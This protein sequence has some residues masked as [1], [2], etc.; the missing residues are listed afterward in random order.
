[1]KL[2]S[3]TTAVLTFS[4]V[5][6][7]AQTRPPQSNPP[8][9][10]PP[11]P[12]YT[13]PAPLPGSPT[14]PP[15]AAPAPNEQFNY[16]QR[17]TASR[18]YLV[19]PEQAQA[20][21]TRF[22]DTYAKLGNPRILIY[23]NRELI[24]EEAGLKLSARSEQTEIVRANVNRQNDPKATN[25]NQNTST[26]L[27]DLSNALDR[28]TGNGSLTGQVERAS[29][30]NTYR[31]RDRKLPSLTDKQTVRDVERLFGRPLRLSG[32]TLVDQRLAT[33]LIPDGGI[34]QLSV[35]VEGEQAR[36]ERAALT[37]VADVVLEVLVSS[38]QVTAN[39]IS[40]PRTYSIP[41]L[42]ATAIR[43]K[44]SKILGQATSADL[45]NESSAR[46]ARSFSNRDIIEATALSLME[47]MMQ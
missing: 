20:I 10:P 14:T 44:D 27:S 19:S 22:K 30:K 37:H 38:K 31:V 23:V 18:L 15:A 9:P 13:A 7:A 21:I 36:K 8:P 33:Q 26:T 29:N 40:G 17:P 47:D 39:E 25:T 11:P 34:K 3:F 41:D 2:S 46:M 45:V 4:S 1:M 42:Q 32:A 12:V 43:L 28:F 24:D 16:E 6:L 5:L 35:P